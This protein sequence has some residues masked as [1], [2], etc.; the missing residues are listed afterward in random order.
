MERGSAIPTLETPDAP[1]RIRPN[2]DP[3]VNRADHAFLR[4]KV[5]L[6]VYATAPEGSARR[7][8]FTRI[9][10]GEGVDQVAA[11]LKSSAGL[12]VPGEDR[13]L[14]KNYQRN[15][16][17]AAPRIELN[18]SV[19]SQV[20]NP[21]LDKSPGVYSTADSTGMP[22][23][24]PSQ[25]QAVEAFKDRLNTSIVESAQALGDMESKGLKGT[26]PYVMALA[27]HESLVQ[28]AAPTMEIM[29]VA[30]ARESAQKNLDVLKQ[31]P[32]R[33]SAALESHYE[34]VARGGAPAEFPHEMGK[35]YL[36]TGVP[37][38]TVNGVFTGMERADDLPLSRKEVVSHAILAEPNAPN[39]RALAAQLKSPIQELDLQNPAL[40]AMLKD[41]QAALQQHRT[42]LDATI[43]EAPAAGPS[44]AERLQGST[45]VLPIPLMVET[46]ADAASPAGKGA[47]PSDP[48]Q[49]NPP[50]PG[51]PSAGTG[52]PAAPG[53]GGPGGGGAGT[54]GL[55]QGHQFP[56]V[57]P[58]VNKF[59]PTMLSPETVGLANLMKDI[60]A[61]E[62]A[63][64]VR[65]R[66]ER[67]FVAANA[68]GAIMTASVGIATEI[69]FA[70]VNPN[71]DPG[72]ALNHLATGFSTTTREVGQ[73]LRQS[74]HELTKADED[75]KS[76]VAQYTLEQRQHA[77]EWA[78]KMSN[79]LEHMDQICPSA[80]DLDHAEQIMS[81]QVAGMPQFKEQYQ[82]RL[83]G[84]AYEL[85]AAAAHELAMSSNPDLNATGA[86]ISKALNA[87]PAYYRGLSWEE[88]QKNV[89]TI[90]AGSKDFATYQSVV[91]SMERQERQVYL[92][93]CATKAIL[94]H[95]NSG[96]LA[97]ALGA[98]ASG[99]VNRLATMKVGDE[100]H[101]VT[102]DELAKAFNQKQGIEKSIEAS[103]RDFVARSPHHAEIVA[104]GGMDAYHQLDHYYG[105]SI[106]GPKGP[107]T[108][109]NSPDRAAARNL[110]DF[111]ADECQ[112]KSEAGNM[113]ELRRGLSIPAGWGDHTIAG[114]RIGLA[115][116]PGEGNQALLIG[117]Q[118][119]SDR[120]KEVGIHLF[121][122]EGLQTPTSIMKNYGIDVN[123]F[124]KLRK[125]APAPH[126][127][128]LIDGS[129][130]A[131]AKDPQDLANKL[132][133]QYNKAV[134]DAYQAHAKS[135]LESDAMAYGDI[136]TSGRIL[137]PSEVRPDEAKV[138]ALADDYIFANRQAYEDRANVLA[139]REYMQPSAARI[140]AAQLKE[141]STSKGF[142][143]MVEAGRGYFNYPP[144]RA[145]L[146]V[147][148]RKGLIGSD[149]RRLMTGADNSFKAIPNDL[150]TARKGGNI[151]R[152]PR[153]LYEMEDP[154]V[155]QL[156][157]LLDSP[158]R[159]A[160]IAAKGQ[161]F[162]AIERFLKDQGRS[163][164]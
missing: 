88:L 147:D 9:S 83:N 115:H 120:I 162:K 140:V 27:K 45:T 124:E 21:A 55:N 87:N 41:H 105:R 155:A 63:A 110:R 107:I 122:K 39:F 61:A 65:I 49:I 17:R 24:V 33:V 30:Q 139:T 80:P 154:R 129:D 58:A 160:H 81:E 149:F 148:P 93:A 57:D 11:S 86:E 100:I 16:L 113:G 42:N 143:Q 6:Q 76:A 89:A 106:R 59:R 156:A 144:Y 72:R 98:G 53:D 5:A 3:M 123:Q 163:A 108:E 74:V 133:G 126:A 70:A 26:E 125:Q 54:S 64:Q 77:E 43:M 130:I 134:V 29:A 25:V 14:L 37:R 111:F 136:K 68:I 164:S 95:A 69:G 146:D 47:G 82:A 118:P 44:L 32:G 38:P 90:G 60:K 157:S 127:H 71:A 18:T 12:L 34:A 62:D 56:N 145:A 36:G 141:A 28:S 117:Y 85:H 7:E 8:L 91:D 114:S 96:N 15:V 132:S 50:S 94:D 23:L 121:A 52:G 10:E 2:L 78:E 46:R 48:T 159:Q 104:Q 161:D 84:N 40:E 31:T 112:F 4:D 101:R 119:D 51:T 20:R 142:N 99:L 150:R 79:Q 131:K 128:V 22:K 158:L 19:V 92:Q 137:Q 1:S 102:P 138:R 103:W 152:N 67:F 97:Q 13:E 151:S 109:A 75:I 35:G 153:I 66:R 73:H 135:K 116:S